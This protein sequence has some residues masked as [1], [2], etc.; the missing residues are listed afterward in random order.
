MLVILCNLRLNV[1]RYLLKN[2]LVYLGIVVII[3]KKDGF[4]NMPE[5]GLLQQALRS[6]LQNFAYSALYRYLRP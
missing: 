4:V 6:K 5:G 2:C 1:S 3:T